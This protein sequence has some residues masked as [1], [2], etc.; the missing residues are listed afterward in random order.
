MRSAD[1]AAIEFRLLGSVEAVRNGNVL[2]LGGK[3]QR[4]LLGLLL[5]EAGRP[6]SPDRLAEELWHGAPP[7]GA[8]ATLPTYV[9][10]LRAVLGLEISSG[11]AGY[12]LVVRPEQIDVTRFERLVGEGRDAL[13]RRS[14]RVA[15]ARLSA[16]L[17]LW[18]GPPFADV[19]GEGA[20]RLEAERLEE[21]RLFAL[22]EQIEAELQLGAGAGLVDRLEALV[23]EHPYRERFWQH[24]MLALYRAQRQADALEAYQRAYSVLGDDLGLEPGDQ[25]KSLEQAILR[26]EVEPA[27]PPEERHNLRAPLTSFIGREAE[28]SEIAKLLDENRLVTLTGVGG[29][30]KTRLALEAAW[31]E[32]A[33]FPDGVYF[34]D[35]SGIADAGLIQ[36][37][38][39][40]A[41]EVA[42]QADSTL[43]EA[44]VARLRDADLLLVL[45]NCEHVLAG[46]A[47][48]TSRLLSACP[49]LRVIA[50]SRVLL[51][52]PGE[53]D[54]AVLP[55]AAPE[56]V[57]LFLARAR[58][59]RPRLPDDDRARKAA[60]AICA[61][62]DELPLAIELA[63]ARAKAL[64]LEEIAT[65]LGDR[66]RFLVSWRRLT[67]TRHRTL[68]EAMDWSHDLLSLDEQALLARLSVFSGGF[69]LPAVAA[70]CLQGDAEGALYL[71]ER[72]VEASL[73][74]AEEHEDEM[75]YRLLET[76]RQYAAERLDEARAADE[77]Q[78]AHA[79]YYLEL[80]EQCRS[81]VYQ[82][83]TP[84]LNR[85]IPED[86][87]LR[88]SLL[89]LTAAAPSGAELRLCAALWQY[90]WLRGEVADGRQR[91][92]AALDRDTDAPIGAK[93]EALVGAST[94]ALR[95]GDL[96]RA[97]AL[98]EESVELAAQ[99]DELALARARIALGNAVGS[100]GDLQ[101]AER[102]YEEG[103]AVFRAGGR[104]WELSNV[105]MNMGDL[106][107]NRGDLDSAERI[108]SESL[109]LCRTLGEDI[110]VALNLGNLA[111][112]EL[113]RGETDRAF[114]R[115]AEGLEYATA[116]GFREWIAIMLVGLAA[117]ASA[118]GDDR[119][120]AELLGACERMLGDAG[121]SLD[122][123]EALI[124]ERTRAA[125]RDRL[126]E[127]EF[128]AALESGRELSAAAAAALA[129]SE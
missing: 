95:Q 112:I 68:R 119:R 74:V 15:A 24:L 101:R 2:P 117:V 78:V 4:A 94:F 111:F 59:V 108:A 32:L 67:P 91:L 25:L 99:F 6:V 113:E 35:L 103:A 73:V 96:G 30:G 29:V 66:F 46:C 63:A 93:A 64:S 62:L 57:E 127:E 17:E 14:P 122:S 1:E 100:L 44:L 110:G 16:A 26:H 13:A 89:H 70:V 124:H 10:R 97:A 11:P 120:A 3:R 58:A 85:L 69:T 71:V 90:W 81:D 36:R 19:G 116:V 37:E 83:G 72:L 41:V 12:A 82:F 104:T 49:R 84:T 129:V 31:R 23:G 105:L 61:D 114:A 42:D 121:A 79:L 118:R 52:T 22:E 87:N 65:R 18:R 8:Q 106:A 47:D 102:L 56:A 88:A 60:A 77:T 86:A 98:A 38:I 123:I 43:D 9:S 51:G 40:V 27:T 115:L 5:L 55:P 76:V 33:D 39:A 34:V 20:L 21:L 75:R 7:P 28:L 107:V 109:S 128:G 54:Y 48:L 53:V 50:T 80:A 45:D 126:G 125:V 92:T